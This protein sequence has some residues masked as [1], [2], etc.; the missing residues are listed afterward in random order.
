MGEKSKTRSASLSSAHRKKY[1]AKRAQYK[2]QSDYVRRFLPS[3]ALEANKELG[4]SLIG[5]FI[6]TDAWISYNKRKNLFELGFSNTNLELVNAFRDLVFL[7]LGEVPSYTNVEVKQKVSKYVAPWHQNMVRQLKL[8]CFENGRKTA[9]MLA[10]LHDLS[11]LEEC[12]RIAFS[13][14]GFV[15]FYVACEKYGYS[16][17]YYSIIRPNLSLGCKPKRLREDWRKVCERLGFKVKMEKDRIKI[18]S[19]K[20]L[21][22]F[23]EMGG[24]LPK[25]FIGGD[26]KFFNGKDKNTVLKR[27][28]YLKDKKAINKQ[29]DLK[30]TSF[31]RNR[32]IK[33][34][35]LNEFKKQNNS[36]RFWKSDS[37][38]NLS[39]NKAIGSL[40]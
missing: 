25:T 2:V 32:L 31:L 17:K 10:K 12:M 35:E 4:I 9:R 14:D 13:C 40:Q 20:D 7:A 3:N 22:K 8:F 18:C 37:P 15:S 5:S 24:F 26:S 23:Q 1:L 33:F 30:E 21:K 39:K 11:F 38:F 6:L 27:L 34:G 36:D 28:L 19:W 16:K 29:S